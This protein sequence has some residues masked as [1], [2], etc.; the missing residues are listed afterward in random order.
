MVYRLETVEQVKECYFTKNYCNYNKRRYEKNAIQNKSVIFL[1]IIVAVYIKII[2][3][4]TVPTSDYVV[5]VNIVI[6]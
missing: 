3:S 6:V 5:H 1:S 4:N 2:I